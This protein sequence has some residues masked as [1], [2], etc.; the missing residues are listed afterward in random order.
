MKKEVSEV[1]GI[2][3]VRDG[4]PVPLDSNPKS[5]AKPHPIRKRAFNRALK[6]GELW[7]IVPYKHMQE[8]GVCL[9][10][11]P[12]KFARIIPDMNCREDTA[13]LIYDMEKYK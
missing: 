9:S 12:N 6:R 11:G 5:G 3:L 13:Y 4:G 7:A 10:L 8:G 1:D 2:K